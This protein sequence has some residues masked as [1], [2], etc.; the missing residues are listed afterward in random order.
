MTGGS[1][2]RGSFAGHGQCGRRHLDPHKADKKMSLA[3]MAIAEMLVRKTGDSVS[4]Q[5]PAAS[6]CA[7]RLS[8][9]QSV[10]SVSE[11]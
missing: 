1:V 6:A 11:D 9:Q 3:Q 4:K 10:E 2:G 5:D 8:L 7:Q